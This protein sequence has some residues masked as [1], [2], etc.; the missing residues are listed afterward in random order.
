M[1]VRRNSLSLDNLVKY[2]GREHPR[3]ERSIPGVTQQILLVRL[4]LATTR[5]IHRRDEHAVLEEDRAE[6]DVYKQG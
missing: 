1:P 3:C 6:W 2:A 5:V 4:N